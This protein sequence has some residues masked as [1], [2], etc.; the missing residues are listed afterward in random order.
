MV[1]KAM[2]LRRSRGRDTGSWNG[3]RG[4]GNGVNTEV[5]LYE[6]LKKTTTNIKKANNNNN[7]CLWNER[8]VKTSKTLR[9]GETLSPEA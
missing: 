4:T 9:K 6:I 2:S 7:K 3:R 5:M 8:M 1:D